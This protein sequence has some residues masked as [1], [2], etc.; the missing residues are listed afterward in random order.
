[1]WDVG[2]NSISY[3]MIK[4]E[5]TGDSSNTFFRLKCGNSKVVRRME[6]GNHSPSGYFSD[7]VKI[8]SSWNYF[9]ITSDPI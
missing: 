5:S 9:N 1:M 6:P 4:R 3:P 8:K 2:N 7:I